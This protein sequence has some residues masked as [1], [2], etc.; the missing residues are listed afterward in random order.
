[1]QISN[2]H[3][4]ALAHLNFEIKKKKNVSAVATDKYKENLKKRVEKT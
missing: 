4:R 1:M 2:Q 3:N